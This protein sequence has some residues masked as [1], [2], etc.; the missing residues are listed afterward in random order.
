[1]SVSVCARVRRYVFGICALALPVRQEK[2]QGIQD[3]AV[4][5]GC[6]MLVWRSSE[7]GTTQRWSEKQKG[8]R[9]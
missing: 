1:M 2:V 9:L 4:L 3:S 7:A 8:E 6:V 5:S